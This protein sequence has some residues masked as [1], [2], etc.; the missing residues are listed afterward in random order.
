MEVF[1]SSEAGAADSR[2]L[3]LQLLAP[4][5]DLPL[6]NITWRVYLKREMAS[7]EVDGL[8]AVEAG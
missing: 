2:D 4:K 8:A 1:Y 7:Q 5:F 3:D 6:E